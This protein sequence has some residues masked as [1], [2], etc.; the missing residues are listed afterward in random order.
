[1]LLFNI[2]GQ[3]GC[4]RDRRRYLKSSFGGFIFTSFHVKKVQRWQMLSLIYLSKSKTHT[5]MHMTNYIDNQWT[6]Q[7]NFHQDISYLHL[8]L[9]REN[10][11]IRQWCERIQWGKLGLLPWFLY[12]FVLF[13]SFH[14]VLVDRVMKI[15]K[16]YVIVIIFRF[17][18]ACLALQTEI[19]VQ[20]KC[21]KCKKEVTKMKWKQQLWQ[22]CAAMISWVEWFVELVVY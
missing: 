22:S 1:M 20:K 5:M 18:L 16:Y 12:P 7:S 4:A 11:L 8:V 21:R 15:R 3:A 9:S 6:F 14:S 17:R 10:V 2:C 19:I 13:F